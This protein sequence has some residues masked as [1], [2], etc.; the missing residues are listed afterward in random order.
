VTL[1]EYQF[2]DVF[3]QEGNEVKDMRKKNQLDPEA[4]WSRAEKNGAWI[5][6]DSDQ[7]MY[8]YP[9]PVI[10]DLGSYGWE[11]AGTWTT[12]F[13]RGGDFPGWTHPS[14][15]LIFKRPIDQRG[16]AE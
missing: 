9:K 6:R 10:T 5:C 15:T 8:K 1:W 3:W 13:S 11:L 4:D 16:P 14:T 7:D 12:G 2:L